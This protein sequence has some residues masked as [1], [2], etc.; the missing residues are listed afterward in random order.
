MFGVALSLMATYTGISPTNLITT[1]KIVMNFVLVHGAWL[2]AGTGAMLQSNYALPAIEYLRRADRPRRACASI[3]PIGGFVHLYRRHMRR[4]R[5]RELNDVALVGH[6]FGALVISG[7]AD[8]IRQRIKR[9]IFW[10][11]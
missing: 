5:M 9:L 4:D 11:R 6:S 1:G 8:R 7:V 10:M 2:V 3:E